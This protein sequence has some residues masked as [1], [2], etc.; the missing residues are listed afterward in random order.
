MS[1]S[2]GAQLNLDWMFVNAHKDL[3]TICIPVLQ[4]WVKFS[5][6]SGGLSVNLIKRF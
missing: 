5:W 3:S 1:S 4:S 6:K 2:N